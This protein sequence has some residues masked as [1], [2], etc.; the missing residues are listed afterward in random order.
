MTRKE[1]NRRTEIIKQLCDLSRN[2]WARAL[3]C[4]YELLEMEL[5]ALEKS[6]KS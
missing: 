2:G 3:P 4:D 5:R 6:R 1:R